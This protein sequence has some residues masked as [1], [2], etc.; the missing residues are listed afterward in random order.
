MALSTLMLLPISDKNAGNESGS[1]I[2][3]P[4]QNRDELLRNPCTRARVYDSDSHPSYVSSGIEELVSAYACSEFYGY[5]EDLYAELS[6]RSEL[7]RERP[8][9]TCSH[10]ISF[11]S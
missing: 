11:R 7:T 5:T 4:R 1:A 8:P 6:L 2:C 9:N 10:G 3:C